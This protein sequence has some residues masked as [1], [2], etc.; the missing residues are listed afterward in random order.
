MDNIRERIKKLCYLSILNLL[1]FLVLICCIVN[2]N[3][4][5]TLFLVFLFMGLVSSI[6]KAWQ[7]YYSTEK[8]DTPPDYFKN[9]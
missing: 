1:L 7:L 6:Y 3:D 4:D 5:G 8:P 9:E 2:K